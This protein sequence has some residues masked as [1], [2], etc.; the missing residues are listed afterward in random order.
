MIIG[1]EPYEL[2]LFDTTGML[3]FGGSLVHAGVPLMMFRSGGLQSHSPVDLSTDG[4][5][6]GVFQRHLIFVIPERS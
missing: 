1:G 5:V 2:S 6:P 3:H 4:R